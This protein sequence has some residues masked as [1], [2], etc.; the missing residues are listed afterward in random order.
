MPTYEYQCDACGNAFEKM[1]PMSASPIKKCP[2]C[3]KSKVRRLI[4]MGGGL[5]F[6]G[7][8]FYITDYRDEGYKASAK[9]DAG[10]AAPAAST[11]KSSG[12]NKSADNKGDTKSSDKSA[13][14]KGSRDKP[15]AKSEDNK[16]SAPAATE[17][18]PA[19]AP[20]APAKK[21]GKSEK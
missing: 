7:S 21:S 12:D 9:A 10:P 20:A 1:Q 6:K 13:G 4:S 2:K 15:A 16:S 18:K 3:G 17:S 11:D 14:D 5:I 19:P 8:G